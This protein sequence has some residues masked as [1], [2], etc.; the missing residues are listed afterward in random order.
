MQILI[1]TNYPEATIT[2]EGRV[3]RI[4]VDIGGSRLQTEKEG[5][6]TL[7]REFCYHVHDKIAALTRLEHEL[8]KKPWEKLTKAELEVVDKEFW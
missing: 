4:A 5:Q 7:A 2:I 8:E 1:D 3:V 6:D